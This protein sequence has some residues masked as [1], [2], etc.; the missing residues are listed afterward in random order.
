MTL[1]YCEKCVQMTNHDSVCLKCTTPE[2]ETSTRK[3]VEE[4]VAQLGLQGKITEQHAKDIEYVIQ[5]HYEARLREVVGELFAV[6]DYQNT[7]RELNA[8]EQERMGIKLALQEFKLK[9][10]AKHGITNL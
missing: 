10:A 6:M 1:E 3:G 8:E 9:F 5:L 4:L 2:K 7:E